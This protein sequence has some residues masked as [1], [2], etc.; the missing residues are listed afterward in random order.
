MCWLIP[1]IAL[2]ASTRLQTILSILALP[3]VWI[4]LAGVTDRSR[5]QHQVVVDNGDTFDGTFLIGGIVMR[6]P[7]VLGV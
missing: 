5:L 3:T 1:C 4:G 7:Y 6:P 2:P